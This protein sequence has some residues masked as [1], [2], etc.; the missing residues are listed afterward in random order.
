MH[1]DA[2]PTDHRGSQRQFQGERARLW[3][4][5][6]TFFDRLE[7]L[8]CSGDFVMSRFQLSELGLAFRIRDCGRDYVLDALEPDFHAGNRLLCL[9]EDRD[10]YC[11]VRGRGS[12]GYRGVTH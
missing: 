7:S 1:F 6:L 11:E 2:F 3:Q 5:D 4:V 10:F 8:L 9:V 12:R